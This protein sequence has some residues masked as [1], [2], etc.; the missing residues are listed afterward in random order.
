MSRLFSVYEF[1]V[2]FVLVK[3][4]LLYST[5]FVDKIYREGA[6]GGR[7]PIQNWSCQ[8]TFLDVCKNFKIFNIFV[9]FLEFYVFTSGCTIHSVLLRIQS[10]SILK[11]NLLNW[12]YVKRSILALLLLLTTTN[13]N[14][15]RKQ[16]VSWMI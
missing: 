1:L 16:A 3:E 7:V 9:F 10:N 11:I 15:L 8:T 14:R 13:N 4:N 12:N 5:L 2:F 6:R